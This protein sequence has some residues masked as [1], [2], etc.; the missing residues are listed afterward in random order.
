MGWT[1]LKWQRKRKASKPLTND[2]P[3]EDIACHKTVLVL[4]EM[5]GIEKIWEGK[6]GTARDICRTISPDT[7]HIAFSA[8]ENPG[9]F[10]PKL[11]RLSCESRTTAK[12]NVTNISQHPGDVN[13][14]LNALKIVNQLRM[15]STNLRTELAPFHLNRKI[16]SSAHPRCEFFSH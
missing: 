5:N 11:H 15:I 4:S 1:I 10:P 2:G 16:F 7:P 6:K 12:N 3:T 14:I 9:Y 13:R 8:D